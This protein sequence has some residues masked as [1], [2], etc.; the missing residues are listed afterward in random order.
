MIIAAAVIDTSEL[1]ESQ[2]VGRFS[3][4]TVLQALS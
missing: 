4:V 1:Q 2:P 3:K